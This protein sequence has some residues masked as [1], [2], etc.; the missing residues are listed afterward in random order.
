MKKIFAILLLSIFS[1]AFLFAADV[2]KPTYTVEETA[3]YKR[4][5]DTSNNS[6]NFFDDSEKLSYMGNIFIINC[7]LIYR[8]D[9]LPAFTGGAAMQFSLTKRIACQAGISLITGK[10]GTKQKY[11]GA[12]DVVDGDVTYGNFA[13]STKIFLSQIFWCGIGVMYETMIDGY[14]VDDDGTNKL[15]VDLKK[16]DDPA[17]IAAELSF[18]LLSSVGSES[19]AMPSIALRY[20]FPSDYKRKKKNIYVG[21]NFGIALS[22]GR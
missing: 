4:G 6:Y 1:S 17:K 8:I 19:Y 14:Y 18:G 20:N 13:L 10:I 7:G 9:S 12:T 3:K 15:H 2:E 16:E 5:R 21:I 22:L 11:D